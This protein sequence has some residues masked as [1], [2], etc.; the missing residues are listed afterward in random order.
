MEAVVIVR[1]VLL[2][3]ANVF[4]KFLISDL[5]HLAFVIDIELAISRHLF[6]TPFT[7]EQ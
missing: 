1:T 7:I 6:Q 3:M 2:K 5:K 4:E